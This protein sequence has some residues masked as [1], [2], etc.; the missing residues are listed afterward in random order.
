MAARG[1]K[2]TVTVEAR[3]T[4]PGSSPVRW[5]EWYITDRG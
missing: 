5:I 2:L 3:Y 1:G 4:G